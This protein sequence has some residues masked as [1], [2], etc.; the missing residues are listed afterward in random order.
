[1]LTCPCDYLKNEAIYKHSCQ[2]YHIKLEFFNSGLSK[3]N[4][5]NHNG[6]KTH[7]SMNIFPMIMKGHTIRYYS[8]WAVYEFCMSCMHL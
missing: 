7:Q 6:E 8:V 2:C 5:K 1:M 4:F 3:N